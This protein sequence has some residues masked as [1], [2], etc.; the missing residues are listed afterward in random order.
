MA[1]G[2]VMSC[3]DSQKVVCTGV[4]AG[5]TP[6]LG[7]TGYFRSAQLISLQ[8]C[9]PILGFPSLPNTY[10]ELQS[11]SPLLFTVLLLSI[12]IPTCDSG[13]SP[14]FPSS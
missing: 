6:A 2:G 1:L 11:P 8:P 13:R 7:G 10:S 3:D 5:S 14:D 9:S 4:S 12:D